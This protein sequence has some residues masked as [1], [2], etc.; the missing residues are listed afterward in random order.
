MKVASFTEATRAL[1][2]GGADC[3]LTDKPR[4]AAKRSLLHL[5]L[6]RINRLKLNS[7]GSAHSLSFTRRINFAV[8]ALDDCFRDR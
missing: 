1:N 3:V 5:P 8:M 7:E 4:S 2:I 6:D